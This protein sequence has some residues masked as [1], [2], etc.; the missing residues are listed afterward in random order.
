MFNE[1]LALDILVLAVDR[2]KMCGRV[3]APVH[4]V[5]AAVVAPLALAASAAAFSLL[6][7]T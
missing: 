5:V 1:R 3:R 2:L 7:N 6:Y 4:L